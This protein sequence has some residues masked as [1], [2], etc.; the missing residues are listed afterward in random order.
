[1]SEDELPPPSEDE[2][3]PA[4]IHAPTVGVPHAGDASCVLIPSSLSS[5]IRTTP[6]NRSRNDSGDINQ[7]DAISNITTDNMTNI[8][9]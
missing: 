2:I 3:Q 1:M 9:I 5:T 6:V 7:T 8:N 4:P